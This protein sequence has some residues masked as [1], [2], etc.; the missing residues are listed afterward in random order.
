MLFI[1]Y[2]IFLE[3]NKALLLFRSQNSHIDD[4][5]GIKITIFVYSCLS[6]QNLIQR[7]NKNIHYNQKLI[8]K[9][10][11]A[12]TFSITTQNESYHSITKSGMPKAH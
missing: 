9:E 7:K 4:E 3:K 12:N 8:G 5:W 1:N 2:L 6:L 10:K 11:S